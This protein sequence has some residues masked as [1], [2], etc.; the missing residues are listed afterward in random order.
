MERLWPS[1]LLGDR[2]SGSYFRAV[3]V[4]YSKGSLRKNEE[5]GKNRG[6][7]SH[8]PICR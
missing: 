3:S 8:L 2:C 6:W 1:P 4:C 7:N 5:C